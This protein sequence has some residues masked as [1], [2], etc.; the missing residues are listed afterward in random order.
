MTRFACVPVFV[1]GTHISW[2]EGSLFVA[3]YVSYL[4]WLAC[5]RA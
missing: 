1:T 3:L 2:W 4:L 5:F